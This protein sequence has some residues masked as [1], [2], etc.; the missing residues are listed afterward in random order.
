MKTLTMYWKTAALS[1]GLLFFSAAVTAQN[2]KNK[3]I[4]SD[5]KVA[6]AEFLKGDKLMQALFDNSYGYAIFPNMGKG[7][8]GV[9]AAAGSGIVY[10][11][12]KMIGS[13]R[14]KQLNVGAQLGGQ[15]YREVIF[16]ENKDALNRFR[17]NKFEFAAQTSAVAVKE[18]VSANASYRDGV[19]V[20]T[21]EKAGLMYEA[22][23]GGQKFSYTSF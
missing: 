19:M 7:G 4:I 3:R 15:A 12:G 18:G 13:A 1:A 22:S 6:R 20:F 16:F 10:E 21:Q 2:S 23:L 8:A 14:M 9:G 11:K 5:S 17:D